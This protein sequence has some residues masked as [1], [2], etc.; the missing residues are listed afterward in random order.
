MKDHHTHDRV[1]D[2]KIKTT[3]DTL[4]LMAAHFERGGGVRTQIEVTAQILDD[5]LASRR[6]CR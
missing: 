4:R 6:R 3:A 2:R 5:W 1:T